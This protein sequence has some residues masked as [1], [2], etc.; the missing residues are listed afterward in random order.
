MSNTKNNMPETDMMA[1]KPEGFVLV[2]NEKGAEWL[3]QQKPMPNQREEFR[4]K[5]ARIGITSYDIT[6]K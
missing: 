2:L 1:M 3:K 6:R 5:A 4:K